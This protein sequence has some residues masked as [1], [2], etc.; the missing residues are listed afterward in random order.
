VTGG[1]PRA[2]PLVSQVPGVTVEKVLIVGISGGQGR[3]LTRRLRASYRV[4]GVDSIRWEGAPRDVRVHIV[5][6][7]QKTFEDVIRRE[8]P[9]AVVH[10]GFVRSFH[11]SDQ[12]RYDVDSL[13]LLRTGRVATLGWVPGVPPTLQESPAENFMGDPYWTDGYRA[14][15][16]LAGE[17]VVAEFFQWLDLA[18]EIA[19]RAAAEDVQE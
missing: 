1:V 17:P 16:L 19:R 11:I 13:D 7:R 9:N 18:G 2:A 12:E 14:V 8:K 6:I 3:L 5:D 4:C 15:V 10:L